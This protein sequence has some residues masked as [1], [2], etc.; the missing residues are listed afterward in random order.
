MFLVQ[1]Y[2]GDLIYTII[3]NAVLIAILAAIVYAVIK[4]IRK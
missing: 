1:V 3:M 4:F 2:W